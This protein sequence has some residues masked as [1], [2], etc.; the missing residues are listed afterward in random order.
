MPLAPLAAFILCSHFAAA[1]SVSTFPL[2]G[3]DA[4]KFDA[5]FFPEGTELSISATGTVVV[6]WEYMTRPDGSLSAPMSPRDG[7]RIHG[8]PGS[9]NYPTEH[10]GDGLNH[11]DGGG[12]NYVVGHGD[13]SWPVAGKQTTDTRDDNTI[14]F[15][16]VIGTFSDT[17]AR[18]DWFNIGTGTKV[19]VPRG[20]ARLYLLVNDSSYADNSGGYWI[21]ITTGHVASVATSAGKIS[22]ASPVYAPLA[23]TETLSKHDTFGYALPRGIRLTHAIETSPDLAQW[24]PATNLVFFFQDPDSAKFSSRFYRFVESK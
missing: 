1:A 14:R 18:A 9:T 19:T 2:P 20:G 5:G 23:K 22:V 17:P 15:G 6:C 21:T 24:T 8:T 13:I 7:A 4:V 10:G 11:F 16:A 12:M 3:A